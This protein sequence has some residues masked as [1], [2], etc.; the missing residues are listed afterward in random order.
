MSAHGWTT[1]ERLPLPL[2]RR[3]EDGIGA[4]WL[5]SRDVLLYYPD[6]T[7]AVGWAELMGEWEISDGNYIGRGAAEVH[8]STE[9]GRGEQ[10]SHWCDLPPAPRG[11][12]GY[13][14]VAERMQGGG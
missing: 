4:E 7:Q 10:P 9:D 6:G 14:I 8:W 1:T 3:A 12:N 5:Q 11:A 2:E 13:A